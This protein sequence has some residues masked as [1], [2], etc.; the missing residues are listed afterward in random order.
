LREK[1]SSMA[2]EGSKYLASQAVNVGQ[3]TFQ[4]LVSM[5]IML[6][7]LFFL[8][9]DGGNLARHSKQLIPL[10]DEH[11]QHLFRKFATVVRAT[12]KGN[13]VVA[14][15]QGALGGLM[16]WFLGIQGALL[17][18]VLMAFLSLMPA[19]G[20]AIIWVPVAVSFLVT[21][22]VWPG[23]VLTLFGV[24]VIGLVDNI[25]RPLLVG[26]DTKIPDYVILVS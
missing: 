11:Q 3:N 18:G 1:L 10:S 4:F 14:A 25:L 20:A 15:T 26:K 8:L 6:Y 23:I 7:L 21:G 9:R 19:V 13:I 24:L 2:L 16:F 12:V 17:W 5:G 22:A